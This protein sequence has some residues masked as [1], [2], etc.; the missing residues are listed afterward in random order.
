MSIS[1][2]H[3][4]IPKDLT[5]STEERYHLPLPHLVVLPIEVQRT[6]TPFLVCHLWI[7]DWLESIKTRTGSNTNWKTDTGDQRGGIWMGADK[8]SSRRRWTLQQDKHNNQ[9]RHR[10]NYPSWS[11][12]CSHWISTGPRNQ[13]TTFRTKTHQHAQWK[14]A[15]LPAW[16][17]PVRQMA[18]ASQIDGTSQTGVQRR[19]G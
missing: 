18:Y 1:C 16:A 19:S 4:D 9:A 5:L 8:N 14:F 11:R 2:V 10:L 12:S 7:L 6:R 3:C 17:T 13:H 15:R